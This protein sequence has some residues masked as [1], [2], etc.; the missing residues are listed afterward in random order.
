MAP[1]SKFQGVFV[2]FR[3]MIYN[4]LEAILKYTV[5][6]NR[7]H[8]KTQ[9]WASF[10]IH[11]DKW[12]HNILLQFYET[13]SSYFLH[14]PQRQLSGC[15]WNPSFLTKFLSC[16]HL[17]GPH[18]TG[19]FPSVASDSAASAHLTRDFKWCLCSHLLPLTKSRKHHCRPTA[20][21]FHHPQ[22]FLGIELIS[23][24]SSQPAK[25]QPRNPLVFGQN[26]VHPCFLP[27][28]TRLHSWITIS[29]GYMPQIHSDG[30]FP[31]YSLRAAGFL[32]SL[33]RFPF[34][35]CTPCRHYLSLHEFKSTLLLVLAHLFHVH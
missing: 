20:L 17:S 33:F 19:S 35:P 28:C 24:I 9:V 14:D 2:I 32:L 8:S 6:G 31:T 11:L 21:P 12:L 30:M 22:A 1:T 18:L 16:L 5:T 10:P 15:P 29:Y 7:G 13:N 25:S 34:P 23:F 26:P 4:D 3:E 27:A